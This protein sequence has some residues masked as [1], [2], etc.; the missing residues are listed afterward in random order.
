LHLVHR[1]E[2]EWGRDSKYEASHSTKSHA[3]LLEPT[4]EL[5]GVGGES[6]ATLIAAPQNCRSPRKPRSF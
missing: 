6:N 5:N 4:L 2:Q 3:A 1:I